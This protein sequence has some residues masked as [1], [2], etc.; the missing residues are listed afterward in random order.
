M[1][2]VLR[3][4]AAAPVGRRMM[5]ANVLR[6]SVAAAPVGRRMMHAAETPLGKSS[7][8][9]AALLNG[10]DIFTLQNGDAGP[11]LLCMPGAMGTAETDFAPQL[12]G[13]SD[14]MQVVSYDPRGYGKS[15]TRSCPVRDFP[16]GRVAHKKDFYQPDFYQ[17]DADDAA[18]LMNTL[19]H[20][21]YTVCGW[22]DG[23]ISAVMLAAANPTI[24]ERL[25][26]FGGNAYFT[27]EDID[28]FEATRDIE[29][30]WSQRMKDTHRPVYGD[31]LQPMW[32]GAVDA[33]AAIF[34]E[35][36]GDV[37]QTQAQAIKCPTL[38]LHGAKDPMC[39]SEHPEWF[40]DNIPD[41]RLHIFPDG[42]HNIHIKFADEFNALVR[43][44]VL[45]NERPD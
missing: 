20:K 24:V 4:V 22:S 25:V 10:A 27:Q 5:H 42:K 3:S 30:N 26:I 18:S 40:V 45:N 23:A 19:G 36:G 12:T 29:A 28:A 38:V 37:C 44:F 35:R 21:K 43:A 41:A 11:A 8:V 33:W 6:R 14:A 9:H 39:L 1:R 17:R 7:T 32:D 13:L 34:A 16:S 15:R 31:D 2:N